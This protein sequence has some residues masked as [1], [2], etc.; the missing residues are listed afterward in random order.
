MARGAR[1]AIMTLTVAAACGTARASS[2]E[3]SPSQVSLST[4]VPST[5]VAISN[6][7]GE[8][9][10]FHMAAFGWRQKA[11]GGA[12]L[13]P[14]GDVFFFPAIV[15]LGPGE[16]KLVRVGTQTGFGPT[17]KAYSL[18]VENIDEDTAA[19]VKPMVSATTVGIPIFVRP[20]RPAAEARVDQLSVERGHVRLKVKNVGTAHFRLRNVQL[21]GD[22]NERSTHWVQTVPAWYMLPGDERSWDYELPPGVCDGLS[23]LSVEF[24]GDEVGGRT[25]IAVPGGA[26]PE[27]AE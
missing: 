18:F 2:F 5:M 20:T 6:P 21:S 19:N 13:T 3:V 27:A 24:E 17:E 10:R 25:T 12:E 7:S 14:T 26:C 11:N 9:K 8:A 4:N 16:T 15:E 1:I 23:R 22:G